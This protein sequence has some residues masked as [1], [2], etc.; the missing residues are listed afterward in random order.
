MRDKLSSKLPNFGIKYFKS[1]KFIL[2]N[3]TN[4]KYK[5]KQKFSKIKELVNY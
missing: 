5:V 1:L 3:K 4:T 2:K